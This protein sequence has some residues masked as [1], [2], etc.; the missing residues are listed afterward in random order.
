MP[1]QLQPDAALPLIR[2]GLALMVIAGLY[3]GQDVLIPIALAV[4]LSFVLAPAADRLERWRLPPVPSVIAT[5]ILAFS[6]LGGVGLIVS[7]QVVSLAE[8]L[9]KYRDNIT[10]RFLSLQGGE[11]G[12]F[13]RA[14]ETF[15]AIQEDIKKKPAAAEPGVAEPPGTRGL[16]DNEPLTDQPP[17]PILVEV[18]EE[19]PSTFELLRDYVSPALIPLARL[20]LAV[21]LVIFFLLQREDL[22]DRLIRLMS[23]DRL[24]VTTRALNDA[25]DRIGRY[26]RTQLLINTCYGVPIAIGLAII[27]LPGALLWGLLG[28]LL[29]FIPYVG[30]WLA[31]S[32]PILLSLAV[33]D[34]WLWPLAVI[35]LFVGLELFTNMVME[36][37]LYGASTGLSPVA[38]LL[39]V[40]FWSSLWG[41][42]GLLLA[43][44]LTVCLVVAGRHLPQFEF[45]TILL[46]KEPALSATERFYQRLLAGDHQGAMELALE[47]GD[48]LI[49]VYDQVIIPALTLAER[50]RHNGRLDPELEQFIIESASEIVDALGA[51]ESI[52][53]NGKAIEPR[54]QHFELMCLPSRDLADELTARMF[55]QVLKQQGIGAQHLSVKSLASEMV[56]RVG[57]GEQPVVCVSALPPKALAHTRYLCKRLKQQFPKARIAVGLWNTKEYAARVTPR[58]NEAGADAVLPNLAAGVKW[59]RQRMNERATVTAPKILN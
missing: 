13:D 9:P 38:V 12:V 14:A 47:H 52:A 44:P 54:H 17:E 42:V 51:R 6:I 5:V 39:A 50:D 29:R 19:P 49:S 43:I 1:T 37:W 16:Q 25:G 53:A 59:A 8:S 31:A 40:I 46:G 30:P 24:D 26:L 3:L 10:Q 7:N 32:M 33:F 55:A 18:R 56:E 23:R 21:V 58:L 34:G 45:F 36:P 4:L 2:F 20:G 57:E 15:F 27:G 11:G 41:G 28:M 48:G 35:A 22:R